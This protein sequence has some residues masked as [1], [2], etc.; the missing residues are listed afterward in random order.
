MKKIKTSFTLSS[1][2]I[3][4]LKKLAEKNRRSSASMI[5]ELIIE[6][7]AKQKIK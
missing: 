7:A 3:D 5:E 6:A 4:L 2:A 1:D